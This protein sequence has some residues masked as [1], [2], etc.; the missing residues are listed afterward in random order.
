MDGYNNNNNHLQHQQ[1][2]QQM[3]Q[4]SQQQQQQLLDLGIDSSGNFNTMQMQS[5]PLSSSGTH[6][7]SI[8]ISISNSGNNIGINNMSSSTD[9]NSFTTSNI[10]E[11]NLKKRKVKNEDGTFSELPYSPNNSGSS[12]GSYLLDTFQQQFQQQ[13][14]H[15]SAFTSTNN[16]NN[17]LNASANNNNINNPPVSPAFVPVQSQLTSSSLYPIPSISITNTN[18]NNNNNHSS[19]SSASTL[20]THLHSPRGGPSPIPSPHHS[21]THSPLHS[22]IHSPLVHD[23][24]LSLN[25]ENENSDPLSP[26]GNFGADA[27]PF[28]WTNYNSEQW[29]PT[30]NTNGEEM[31]TP[32]LNII[33][34]K[35]FTYLNNSWI[36]CRRNHF[37]LDITA[38]YPKAFQETTTQYNNGISLSSSSSSIDPTQ[39]P[40][41]LLID[42]H[43]TPINGLTLTIKGIKN[44]TD[45]SQ[46]EAEV[47]LFQTNSKREKQGEHAPKPVAIQFGS[48]VSIQRLHFRKATM[49]NA[50]R[51]GQ[52]NPHQEYNQ[53]V[54]SLYGRCMAQ[55]Y[56]IVSY[57]SPPLI[58]RTAISSPSVS[59]APTD[60]SPLHTPDINATSASGSFNTFGSN[61][62]TFSDF[63]NMRLHSPGHSPISP[64]PSLQ[65][66]SNSLSPTS[67]QNI[68]QNQ[69]NN[70]NNNNNITSNLNNI[71]G[72]STTGM[73]SSQCGWNRRDDKTTTFNGKVGINFEAP[74]FELAVQGT[75]YASQGVF[76]P[77]DLRIKYDLENVDTR[78]NLENVNRMKIY[79][80]KINPQWA[81]M[82]GRD[83][84]G[85][86]SDRGVIAQDLQRVIPRSVRTIGNRNVNGKE[87]DNFLVINNEGI[88]FENLGATQ[89][90][91]KQIDRLQLQLNET[92]KRLKKSEKRSKWSLFIIVFVFLILGLLFLLSSPLNYS[93]QFFGQK[94]HHHH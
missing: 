45:M 15:L 6:Q 81:Y 66:S 17:N 28:T 53:L 74:T 56:C 30:F 79:D 48:L 32:Q 59:P 3:M 71:I 9:Y 73:G 85:D 40:S 37:Q 69:N 14:Q 61:L 89:E 82:N 76:H 8:P 36:Y 83:P 13:Q 94:K 67:S 64:R 39:T 41:Y 21:P 63:S 51:N 46:Q 27:P 49:N 43:K 86:N 60:L 5:I 52:P 68:N 20:G 11:T 31:I 7:Q 16:N 54:V 38:F 78:S 58:V 90:L 91:S 72:T 1:H 10:D 44:R 12:S 50:R 18:N 77:S 23:N 4:M 65:P 84:Y 42:G 22:P 93:Q 19:T 92:E 70:N 2:Q 26:G 88:M 55:E 62:N 47:E 80:Y 24:Y 33:A 25:S 34:S 57:V 35:G 29:Y 75:I 87:I